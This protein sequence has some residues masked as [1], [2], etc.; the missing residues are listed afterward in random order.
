MA[1]LDLLGRRWALGILWVLARNSPLSFNSLQEKCESISPAVLNVRLK[2][3]VIAQLVVRGE[4]G[5][6]LSGHGAALYSMLEPLGRW[7]KT[8][9]AKALAQTS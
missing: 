7:S 1:L 5:Y 4:E 2:E 8:T 6:A 9:W 3:L